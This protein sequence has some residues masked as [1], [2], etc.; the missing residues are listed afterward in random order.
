MPKKMVRSFTN[1]IPTS[2]LPMLLLVTMIINRLS[3]LNLEA[4]MDGDLKIPRESTGI[5]R[6]E[7]ADHEMGIMMGR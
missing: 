7:A 4:N 2:D 3:T 5:I 6:G 1:Q